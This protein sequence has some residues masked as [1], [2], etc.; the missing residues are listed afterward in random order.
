MHSHEECLQSKRLFAVNFRHIEEESNS[1]HAARLIQPVGE[2]Q[3]IVNPPYPPLTTDEL[4]AIYD[5]PFT[6]LPHPKYKGKEISAYNMIRHSII[7][8]QGMF[9]GMCFLHDFRPSGQIHI[10][11]FENLY[12]AGSR[13]NMRDAGL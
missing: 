13:A 2:Q 10:F 6:R 7:H 12:P 11:P 4:D 1:I 9:R 5:L 8:A 3:V